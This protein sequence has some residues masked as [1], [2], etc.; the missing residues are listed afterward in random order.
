MKLKAITFRE[1]MTQNF[2]LGELKVINEHGANK[3]WKGLTYDH[4]IESLYNRY[5]PEIWETLHDDAIS[6][7]YKNAF[8]LIAIFRSAKEIKSLHDLKVL[9]VWYT[10]EETARR[11]VEALE[12]L[13]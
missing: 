1:W 3:G 6:Y 8:E 5:E 9:L 2:S 7:G 4:E 10:A 12:Y 11:V 13:E